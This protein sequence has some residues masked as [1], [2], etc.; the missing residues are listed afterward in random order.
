[1]VSHGGAA[2][3]ACRRLK[4]VAPAGAGG[5]G[6]VSMSWSGMRAGALPNGTK[7]GEVRDVAKRF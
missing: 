6:G 4:A 1:M 5:V 7:L 3:A 2:V